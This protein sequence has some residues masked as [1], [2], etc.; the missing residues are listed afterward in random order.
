MSKNNLVTDIIG[1]CMHLIMSK[2]L[3]RDWLNKKQILVDLHRILR[4]EYKKRKKQELELFIFDVSH[5]ICDIKY[6]LDKKVD[7]K[8]HI[9][10]EGDD[11][12]SDEEASDSDADTPDISKITFISPPTVEAIMKSMPAFN[13]G[14]RSMNQKIP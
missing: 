10:N 12:D 4:R 2:D 1:I 5:L 6:T 13:V 11:G 7:N 8:I 3:L 14:A 9:S